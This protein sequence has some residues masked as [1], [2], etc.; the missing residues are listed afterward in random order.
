ML[1][2]VEVVFDYLSLLVFT[3]PLAKLD[4]KLCWTDLEI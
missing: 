1:L 4:D 3:I 2:K